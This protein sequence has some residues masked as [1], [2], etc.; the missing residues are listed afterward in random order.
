M[1]PGS[2]SVRG[3]TGVNSLNRRAMEPRG[4]RLWFACARGV[5]SIL[6]VLLMGSNAILAQTSLKSRLDFVVGSHPIAA[7]TVDFDG[8]GTLDIITANQLTRNNRDLSLMK[9]VGDGTLRR[10]PSITPRLVPT[11]GAL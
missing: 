4:I 9:G 5:L 3:G 11:G 10:P 1:C 7:V 6:L 8:G 2:A